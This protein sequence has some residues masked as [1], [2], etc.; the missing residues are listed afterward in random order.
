MDQREQ[1]ADEVKGIARHMQAASARLGDTQVGRWLCEVGEQ[2]FGWA[3]KFVNRGGPG[4]AA[5]VGVLLQPP[6]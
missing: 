6:T 2:W 3:R 4:L 5:V 1:E